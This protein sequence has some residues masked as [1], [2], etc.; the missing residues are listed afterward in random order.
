M[1]ETAR[2]RARM[3]VALELGVPL[4]KAKD[5]ATIESLGGDSLDKVGIAIEFEKAFNISVADE[6]IERARTVGDLLA[7]AKN[8][9]KRGK[10]V[11]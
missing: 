8:E 9:P 6:E 11:W 5:A 2:Q 1:A 7:L 4:D 10:R 3:I